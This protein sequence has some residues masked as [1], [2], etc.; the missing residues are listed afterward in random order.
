MYNENINK[1][2]YILQDKIRR[3][4][5]LY[6]Y[7]STPFTE[8]G[9]F[10]Y[11]GALKENFFF[12]NL[13]SKNGKCEEYILKIEKALKNRTYKSILL[14]G[15]QGCGKTTF[16]HYLKKNCDFA[17]F[18][19]F[20]FD[21][22]TSHPSISEYI[23]IFSKYLLNLLKSDENINKVFYNLYSQNKALI[24]EK[25]NANNNTITFFEKFRN[26]FIL[27]KYK[28]SDEKEDFIKEINGLFF[29]Q[30]LSLITLWKICEIK[31]IGY[32]KKSSIKPVIFCLDNLDVL[33]NKEIIEKFFKEYFRF[34]RNIDSIIQNINLKLIPEED[35]CYNDIFTFIFSCRQHTWARVRQHYRHD[36]TF[37]KVST[38]EIN[39]TDAFDKQGIIAQREEY[40]KNNTNIYLDFSDKVSQ[41]KEILSDLDAPEEYRHNIYDL[42]DD[43]YRQCNRTLE[44]ILDS[45]PQIIDEYFEV[46]RKAYKNNLYGARGIVYK[47]I[48]DKFKEEGIFEQIGVLD[49]DAQNPENLVSD[50]RMI[51]NYLY[52]KTF[53]KNQPSYPK[54]IAF[55]KIV[56][57]FKDIIDKE[58]IDKCLLAMFKL[59]DDSSWNEL[60]AFTEINS[61]ELTSCEDNSQ[62]FITKAGKEYLSFMATHFEFF[63]SRANADMALFSPDSLLPCSNT[64]SNYKY[65][66]EIIISNILEIVKNCCARMSIY[67]KSTMK[68]RYKK[69]ENYLNSPFV[70][71]EVKVLHSERII[72]THIRYID[73]FRLYVLH[74]EENIKDKKYI[75]RRLVELISEYISVGEQYEDILTSISTDRLFPKFKEKI[76]AIKNSDFT[77]CDMRIDING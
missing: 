50:V 54:P 51:L 59:G 43:D 40:I 73:N 13:F 31:E 69:V 23:E 62:I 42:F 15:N 74:N 2:A 49:V 64:V 72:H 55:S 77:N 16:V 70:F 18:E 67:Y 11:N 25:I 34:V 24:N 7:R 63:N 66:F 30:I 17:N 32:N 60:I 61:E 76:E 44:E 45:N 58:I 3:G 8:H 14:I 26:I 65:N 36:N 6:Y 56:I 27:K 71:S 57:D 35:Y 21:K 52:C 68:E 39:I 37:V 5:A 46:K 47:S 20:D 1:E 38:L 9:E 10:N 22:N 12:D 19:F 75:N 48:F 53:N 33:V 41:I 4:S 28:D 29:N